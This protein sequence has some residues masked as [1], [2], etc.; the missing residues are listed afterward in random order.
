MLNKT[1]LVSQ[2]WK[3]TESSLSQFTNHNGVFQD[4]VLAFCRDC[5]GALWLLA[6]HTNL[7]GISLWK[8][9]SVDDLVKQCGITYNFEMGRAGEAFQ[10]ISYPDGPLSR[11]QIWPNGLW[12]DQDDGKFY[13]FIHN[14]TGWGA[15][16]TSYTVNG[17]QEGEPDFRHIGLMTSGDQGRSW[18]FEGWVLTS[19]EP[20]W[21]AQYRPE[22]MAGGQEM[23][24][25]NLG[26]GDFS[27]LVNDRDGYFYIFYTQMLWDAANNQNSDFLYAARAPINSKGLPGHWHKY[28]E[29]AYTEPGNLGKETSIV[30]KGNIPCVSYNT[31][32]HKYMM[33][34]YRRDYWISGKGA[35]QV[36]FSD[37]L[38]SWTIPI[39]LDPDREDLSKPYFTICNADISGLHN[40]TGQQFRLFIESN[41]TDVYKVDITIA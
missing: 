35:C 30:E 33:T 6:G 5:D 4:G 34:S 18:D 23:K 25:V 40:V 7:G 39:P 27:L 3:I 26:A 17:Q 20:C 16:D 37:D 22:G 31:Y 13:C 15:M 9:S 41:G 36:S 21:T 2:G 11:G 1:S 29:G 19:H 24:S 38:H 8:G 12:I 32:L 28:Y 14:E 10:G